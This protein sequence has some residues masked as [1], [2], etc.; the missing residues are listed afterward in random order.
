M[1]LTVCKINSC[2]ITNGNYQLA[3]LFRA[4]WCQSWWW[5]A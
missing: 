3:T 5:P 4:S 2:H 1:A